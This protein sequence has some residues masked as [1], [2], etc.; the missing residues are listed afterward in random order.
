MDLDEEVGNYP[1]SLAQPA[2]SQA[3]KLDETSSST[4]CCIPSR[5]FQPLTLM[6]SRSKL[7]YSHRSIDDTTSDQPKPAGQCLSQESAQICVY[8]L[9]I[10][11]TPSV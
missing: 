1:V 4:F 7:E 6:H 11:E 10:A 3:E 5:V 9:M 2:V 8:F